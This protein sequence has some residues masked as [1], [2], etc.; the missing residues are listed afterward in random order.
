MA[1]D[2]SPRPRQYWDDYA[3]RFKNRSLADA[4]EHRPPYPDETYDIIRFLLG[5]SPGRVL[6]VGCGPGKIARILVEHVESV[7]AV[8]F[9]EEMIRVGKSLANGDHPRLTWIQGRVEEVEWNPPYSMV[10]A[11]ASIHWMEW[12]K[13]FPRFRKAMPDGGYVVIIDGDRPVDPSWREAELV[14][15]RKFSTNPHYEE[16]D[17]IQELETR[18]HLHLLGDKLTEPVR[19]SQ[20]VRDYV[21]SFHSRESM[22]VEHMGKENAAVFDAELTNILSD[23]A[24]EAGMLSFDLQTRVSWGRPLDYSS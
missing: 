17:L 13:V 2:T 5:E 22:S 11:G 20:S 16:I 15:I 7:D 1:K 14:L 3:S 21:G 8:D 12:S 19:F 18:R 10:T 23:Y 6:D 24:D 4:Y 9:S